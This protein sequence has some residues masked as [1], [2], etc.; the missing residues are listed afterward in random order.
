MDEPQ[1]A[2]NLHLHSQEWTVSGGPLTIT[3]FL[4]IQPPSPR[5]FNPDNRSGSVELIF[6]GS[7]N[8]GSVDP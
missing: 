5:K 2:Q 7:L 1:S 3:Q 6:T 8:L 4:E